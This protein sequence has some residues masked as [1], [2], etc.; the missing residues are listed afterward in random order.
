[1]EMLLTRSSKKILLAAGLVLIVF[2]LMYRGEL[3]QFKDYSAPFT[4]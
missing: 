1:M 2:Y 4:V 3:S